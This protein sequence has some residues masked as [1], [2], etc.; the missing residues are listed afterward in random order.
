MTPQAPDRSCRP[1]GAEG[2]GHHGEE[3]RTGSDV[4]PRAPAIAA[5]RPV[6][7]G[8]WLSCAPHRPLLSVLIAL[9]LYAIN[10]LG[11][12]LSM[13]GLL[14]GHDVAWAVGAVIEA[15]A[16]VAAGGLALRVWRSR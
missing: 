7:M 11:A 2:S 9:E 10:R 6:G 1:G 5:A 8:T 12:W 15:G 3:A 13:E 14:R 16:L 4:H